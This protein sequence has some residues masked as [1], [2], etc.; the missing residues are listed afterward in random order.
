MNACPAIGALYKQVSSKYI[1]NLPVLLSDDDQCEFPCKPICINRQEKI[2]SNHITILW[3]I[4][5]ALQFEHK[6][7][8]LQHL[9]AD[10]LL[11]W[12]T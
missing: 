1:I 9:L 11:G 6:K 2:K 10:P 3:Y 7:C 4:Q 8:T 12:T 5:T